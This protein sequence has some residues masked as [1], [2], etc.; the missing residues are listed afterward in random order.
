M[1][2]VTQQVSAV[3]TTGAGDA[4]T[5]GFVFKL[6][7]ACHIS[8]PFRVIY[9]HSRRERRM[10]KEDCPLAHPLSCIPPD[11]SPPPPYPSSLCASSGRGSGR[12]LIGSRGTQICSSLRGSGRGP[13]HHK[14]GAVGIHGGIPQPKGMTSYIC[15]GSVFSTEACNRFLLIILFLLMNVV[16]PFTKAA[17]SWNPPPATAFLPQGAIEGQP[18]LPEIQELYE[19]S[20]GW[21]NFW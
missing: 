3:D 14:K 7:Q 20:S 8:S 6:L 4:F 17:S 5:A 15:S 19:T 11:P 18:T 1:R 21:Y 16:K 9:F 12:P 2:Y 10:T 13:D